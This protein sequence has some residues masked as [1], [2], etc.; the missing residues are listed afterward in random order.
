M[1]EHD[2]FLA[3]GGIV[4]LHTG[5]TVKIFINL[6]R[7]RAAHLTIPKRMLEVA[8]EVIESGA[9]RKWKDRPCP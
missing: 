2:D 8:S 9:R 1:G 6:D 5:D 7:A 3:L 4:Q